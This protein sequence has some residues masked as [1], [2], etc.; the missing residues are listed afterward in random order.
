M[1]EACQDHGVKLGIGLQSRHHPA[2]L[3][4]RQIVANGELGRLVFANAQAEILPLWAPDWYYDPAL[5]GGGVLYMLGVHRIDLLRFVLGCEVE[6]VSA[7]VGDQPPERPFEDIVT[8]M[9]KFDNGAYGTMHFSLN[10]PYGTN[11]FDVHGAEAS[12]FGINTTSLWWGGK[13]GELLLNSDAATTRHQ[14]K[15]IDLYRTEIE[16]FNRGIT[17]D[18]CPMATGDDGLRAAE[19]SVAIYESGR[20]GKPVRITDIQRLNQT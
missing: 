18:G 5:A 8:V 15:Q 1:I 14:F 7:Y 20:Q 16:D 10:I 19:I 6:E 9:L 12:M 4:M 13:G 3:K 2:H 11:T 17:E